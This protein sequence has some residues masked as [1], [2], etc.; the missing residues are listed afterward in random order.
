MLRLFILKIFFL[1]Y[2]KNLYFYNF[3]FEFQAKNRLSITNIFKNILIV[4]I[5]FYKEK[6]NVIK[7]LK[8]NE[9]KAKKAQLLYRNS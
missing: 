1:Y 8:I 2:L 5:L 7:S 4:Y 3:I 6:K 9:K